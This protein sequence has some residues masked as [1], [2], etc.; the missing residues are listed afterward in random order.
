[1]KRTALR[2][3]AASLIAGGVATPQLPA[4]A[5][6][7]A[8]A[9]ITI[10]AKSELPKITGDVL[11][12]WRNHALHMATIHGRL[13][14]GTEG[15]ELALYAQQ[16]P[17]HKAPVLLQSV[18]T[19][20][21]NTPY[22]F[23]V[24]PMLATRYQVKFVDSVTGKP[25]AASPKVTVY[26]AAGPRASGGSPCRRRV[27]HQTWHLHVFVPPSTLRTE[28]PKRWFIYFG[29]ALSRSHVPPP[30]KILKLSAGNPQVS[31]PRKI[32]GQEYAVT[33]KFSF[34]IGKD[35]YF[36]SFFP[37]QR[38]AEAKDGLNLPG[39]HGCGTLHTIG[40]KRRYLG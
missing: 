32:N 22:S 15:D 28:M 11:V 37:C 19:S 13:T 20:R 29:L 3:A 2:I 5:T 25:V 26:A 23:D 39:H 14:D 4:L 10:A 1:M 40:N 35:R 17:F 16:F 36:Y 21:A 31:R 18:S 27:C 30:P 12:I 38:D 8:T 33:I 7:P 6:A 24:F 9:T 34:R